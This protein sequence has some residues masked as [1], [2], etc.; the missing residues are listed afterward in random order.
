ML[1]S[2]HVYCVVVAFKMIEWVKQQIC[3]KFFIT[4]EHSSMETIWMIQKAIAMGNWR[5]T[6]PSQQC[7]C[8]WI[9]SH[10]EFFGKTS[11]HPGN[12]GLLQPRFGALWLLA[13]SKIKITFEREEISDY[14][15]DSGKYNRQL[16]MIGRIVCGPRCLLWRGLIMSLPYVQCFLYLVSSINV[17][18]FH[19]TRLDTFWTDLIYKC[20]AVEVNSIMFICCLIFLLL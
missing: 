7:T 19:I 15:W 3:I 13:F 5:V 11:N 6:V 20:S 18:I 8:S 10:A 17:S 12:S 9:T 4:L 14:W 1:L 2:E 16:M